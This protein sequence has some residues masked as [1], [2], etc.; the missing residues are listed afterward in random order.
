M[1]RQGAV[2]AL[3]LLLAACTSPPRSSKGGGGDTKAPGSGELDVTVEVETLGSSPREGELGT[4]I[5]RI[6][7]GCRNTLL[8]KDLSQ[9]RDLMQAGSSASVI[10]WQFAQSGQV[11]YS[12]DRDEWVYDKGRGADVRRPIFNSGL[13]VPD[14]TLVV[15]AQVRLL[16]MPMDF[17]FSYFELTLDEVRRKVYFEVREQKLVRY[18]TLVGRELEDRLVPSLRT[19]E[20]GHRFVVF[21][22]AE[23]IGSNPLLKTFRLQQALRPRFFTLEQACRKAGIPTKPHSG[24]YSYCSVLDGWILPKD[25]GHVLVSSSG[26]LPLPELRQMERSFHF[27]DAIVPE[28]ITVQ[29]RAHS[30]ASALGDLQYRLVKDEKEVPISSTVKEKRVVYYL[31]LTSDQLPKFLADL[32][33][34]KLVLD[35]EYREGHGYLVIHNN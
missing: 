10:T 16:E 32:K 30:V 14:E 19:D 28:K 15:R 3:V 13:L 11:T 24:T 25:Q 4:L 6:H 34:L 8:L 2:A 5:F 33:A 18:R 17:Q 1:A 7:N 26:L 9:P 35:V 23:P 20:A 22:H 31:Y 29:L 21:P 12:V 27:V